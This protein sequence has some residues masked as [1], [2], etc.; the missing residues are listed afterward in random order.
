MNTPTS[1]PDTPFDPID[2]E[3]KLDR[4]YERSLKKRQ[5]CSNYRDEPRISFEDGR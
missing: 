1:I 3:L 2:L 4:A 5:F